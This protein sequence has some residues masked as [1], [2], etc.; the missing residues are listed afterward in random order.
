MP[1]H[2]AAVCLHQLLAKAAYGR[3]GSC[4]LRLWSPSQQEGRAGAEAGKQKATLTDRPPP[5]GPH[6]PSRP[7]KS[8]QLQTTHPNT[9][10]KPEGRIS[11]NQLTLRVLPSS[12]GL[13]SD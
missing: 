7:Q 12:Y 4:D 3:Q 8:L 1:G 9:T 5:A 11:S 2:M 10:S 13:W 6:L